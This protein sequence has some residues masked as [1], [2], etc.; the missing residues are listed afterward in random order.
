[1]PDITHPY[2]IPPG[3][4]TCIRLP[5]FDWWC[6]YYKPRLFLFDSRITRNEIHRTTKLSSRRWLVTTSISFDGA[7]L[8]NQCVRCFSGRAI[9]T[10]LINCKRSRLT[11]FRLSSSFRN[12]KKN[13]V[14]IMEVRFELFITVQTRWLHN[15]REV[16]STILPLPLYLRVMFM[17]NQWQTPT[18]KTFIFTQSLLT[19]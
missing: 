13:T 6:S 8:Y 7:G 9:I 15:K 17:F 16:A 3:A 11:S 2:R 5:T 4:W 18:Y 10:T 12:S 1:M 19:H 14:L